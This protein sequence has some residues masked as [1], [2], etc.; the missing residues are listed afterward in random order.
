MA[1]D[2][3]RDYLKLAKIHR[4]RAAFNRDRWSPRRRALR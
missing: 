4:A 3:F 2:V 1:F